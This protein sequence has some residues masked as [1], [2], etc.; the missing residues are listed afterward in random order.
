MGNSL[1]TLLSEETMF[2]SKFSLS[3]VSAVI[4]AGWTLYLLL[5]GNYY[6]KRKNWMKFGGD[7]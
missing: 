1:L 6:T 3:L 4:K 2:P 7:I 5:R